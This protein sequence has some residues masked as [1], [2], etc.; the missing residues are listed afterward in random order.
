MNY[1]GDVVNVL[2]IRPGERLY[3]RRFGIT[4][5]EQNRMEL[6]DF[7]AS[8]DVL[9]IAAQ[10]G[11]TLHDDAL[12]GPPKVTATLKTRFGLRSQ[13]S[14]DVIEAYYYEIG[15]TILLLLV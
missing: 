1:A 3:S 12:M 9:E 10:D 2:Q 7:D 4:Y 8:K 15:D 5:R 11:G 13:P 14:Q 6:L